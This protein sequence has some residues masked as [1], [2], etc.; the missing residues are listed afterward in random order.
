[1]A[2]MPVTSRTIL[3]DRWT[4]LHAMIKREGL[5]ALRRAG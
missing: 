4:R 5:Q 1:M 2:I 3:E